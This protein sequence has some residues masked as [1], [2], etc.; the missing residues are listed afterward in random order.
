MR[1]SCSVLVSRDKILDVINF[2]LTGFYPSVVFITP[3]YNSMCCDCYACSIITYSWALVIM[4][5]YMVLL[6]PLITL[7]TEIEGL[8]LNSLY[9]AWVSQRGTTMVLQLPQC[10]KCSY[11]TVVALV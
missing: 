11:R 3:V 5:A 6:F 7:C 8:T 1:V 9:F 10:V 2:I 4:H